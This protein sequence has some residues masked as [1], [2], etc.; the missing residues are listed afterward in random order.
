MCMGNKER[1]ELKTADGVV[2]VGS[3]Y[4]GG[5]GSP[6]ILLL[7]MLPETKESWDGF[8]KKL[9]SK[10]F[11]VLT[12]DFRGHG[13]SQGGPDG[14]KAFSEDETKKSIEDARAGFLF[15]KNE[16]HA[17]LF[18]LGASIGA[19]FALQL[20]AEEESLRGGVIMSAGTNYAGVLTLPSASR[21]RAAQGVYFIA[22]K[23]DIR[24]N[25][26]SAGIM[27]QELFDAVPSKDKAI[28]I[29]ESGEHGIHLFQ[30]YPGLEA[31]I[32]AWLE[33]HL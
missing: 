4:P 6:G 5:Q 17:P 29:F 10:G 21:I 3:H 26:I 32:I 23:G 25:G 24:R 18:V 28:N 14:Y 30:S 20:L 11:G 7:H 12:I 9:Q 13:E 1:V 33:K 8:A 2:I 15:Q 16:G 19:N 27:A 22:A 31:S